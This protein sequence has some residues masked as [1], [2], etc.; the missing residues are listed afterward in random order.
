MRNLVADRDSALVQRYRKAGLVI[1]GQTNSPEFGLSPTTEPILN[2]PTHN[3]G[4]QG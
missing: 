1:A 3:P 4:K 2:G